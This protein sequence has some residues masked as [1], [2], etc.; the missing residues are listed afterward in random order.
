[1]RFADPRH[2]V[3]ACILLA[4]NAPVSG[5][6]P[7]AVHQQRYAMGTMFDIVVF[8]HSRADAM[9]VVGEAFA[10]IDR[11]ERVMSHYRSDSDLSKLNREARHRPVRV[12]PSLHEILRDSI[13]VSRRSGGRFDVTIAPLLRLWKGAAAD[14][15]APTPEAL[16]RAR[17]CVG[18]EKIDLSGADGIRF[19]SDCLEVDLS[20]IGKGYAVDRALA[21]LTAAGIQRAMVNAGG[22]SIAAVGGPP[23]R[24]GWPVLLGEADAGGKVLLLNGQSVSTSQRD[25]SKPFGEIIDPLTGAPATGGHS[26]SVIAPTATAS[27]ALSTTVLM[28]RVEEATV[29]LSAFPDVSAVWISPEGQTRAAYRESRLRLRP[30]GN[31]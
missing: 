23:G 22:S 18:Y 19:R 8:H 24:N 31:R 13:E 14:R 20:G 6:A 21:V 12:D 5:G 11:L 25:P 3:L 28:L 4:L 30:P 10:E 9:R 27:D 29:L 16:A 1:M 26:V 7:A 17:R 2:V 15:R